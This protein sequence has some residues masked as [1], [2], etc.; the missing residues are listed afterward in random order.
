[1]E[2]TSM[3]K[4]QLKRTADVLGACPTDDYAPKKYSAREHAAM[5]LKIFLIV[6]V[7]FGLLWLVN[8]LT[9]Q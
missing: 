9:G 4:P 1:M 3:P 2:S 8:A 5:G 6:G 7:L